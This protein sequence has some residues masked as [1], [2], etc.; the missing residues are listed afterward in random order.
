MRISDWSSDVCSSDLLAEALDLVEVE[1]VAACDP[2]FVEHLRNQVLLPVALGDQVME[3]AHGSSRVLR[4]ATGRQQVSTAKPHADRGPRA[5]TPYLT[6]ESADIMR[7]ALPRFLGT[8]QHAPLDKR[9]EEH[10]S[11]LQSLMRISYAVFC[12]KKNKREK[13]RKQ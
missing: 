6:S 4:K 1:I 9:S 13:K 12:L 3:S 5:V 7:A 8:R 10:T 2:G 11:E